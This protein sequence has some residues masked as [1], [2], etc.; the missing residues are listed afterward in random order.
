EGWRERL[1]VRALPL[2]GELPS[3]TKRQQEVWSIIE[4][5]REMPLQEVLELAE[6]TPG[7]VRKLEDKGLISIGPRISER[8]PYAREHILPTQP[9][10]LDAE[11]DAALQ[12]IKAAL[13]A[14]VAAGVPHA[15]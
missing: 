1:Y 9:L 5:W 15:G 7:T 2:S 3:L 11:Q 10:A 8:D 6:T 14:R 12:K 4:E 13:D